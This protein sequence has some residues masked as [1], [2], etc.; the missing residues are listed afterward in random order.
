MFMIA[1][2]DDAIFEHAQYDDD[3]IFTYV[4]LTCAPLR[5]PWWGEGKPKLR[6]QTVEAFVCVFPN[7]SHD[8]RVSFSSVAYAVWPEKAF[9]HHAFQ[10]AMRREH[11]TLL[12]MFYTKTIPLRCL[13]YL[14][15]RCCA[16][17]KQAMRQLNEFLNH[18]LHHFQRLAM[19]KMRKEICAKINNL[20]QINRAAYRANLQRLLQDIDTQLSD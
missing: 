16:P 11:D 7:V 10:E 20:P 18:H 13:E 17:E 2:D 5:Q 9:Q 6:K 19:T 8:V 1:M 12:P 15:K 4:P 3:A 14:V